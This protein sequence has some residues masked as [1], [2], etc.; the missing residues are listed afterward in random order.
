MFCDQKS[1]MIFSAV[2]QRPHLS[3]VMIIKAYI[4]TNIFSESRNSIHS[5][6]A[7]CT[8]CSYVLIGPLRLWTVLILPAG[9]S[10]C[11][12]KSIFITTRRSWIIASQDK[13]EDRQELHSDRQSIFFCDANVPQGL[14]TERHF[15][16]LHNFFKLVYLKSFFIF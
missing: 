12:S 8:R 14:D 5:S 13:P 9:N 7:L 10:N 15:V 3:P 6:V 1:W 16:T 4:H 11:Q 2:T